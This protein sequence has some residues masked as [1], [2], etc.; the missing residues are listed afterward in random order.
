MFYE[1]IER[2]TEGVFKGQLTEES[3][4]GLLD[5]EDAEEHFRDLLNLHPLYKGYIPAFKNLLEEAGMSKEQVLE[6]F[7]RASKNTNWNNPRY[8]ED[9]I[10]RQRNG[11]NY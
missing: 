9:K 11:F 6:I 1:Q 10:R 3:K 2:H 5:I 7:N 8:V 4:K